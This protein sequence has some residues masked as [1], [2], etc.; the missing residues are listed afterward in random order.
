MS[1]I[2]AYATS[3]GIQE[4]FG[5]VLPENETMLSICRRLGFTLRHDID[6]PN[7]IRVSKR[8]ANSPT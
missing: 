7:M 6:A 8:L 5:N 4:I 2:T 1:R 3:S